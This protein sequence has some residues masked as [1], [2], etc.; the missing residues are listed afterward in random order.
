[1]FI[2]GLRLSLN[3]ASINEFA[4]FVCRASRR[5]SHLPRSQWPVTA[6]ALCNK[7]RYEARPHH[8]PPTAARGAWAHIYGTEGERGA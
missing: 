4:T 1:M 7:M 2:V 6:V 3:E 5:A 8:Q